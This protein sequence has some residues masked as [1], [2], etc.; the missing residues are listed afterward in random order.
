MPLAARVG[1]RSSHAGKV[2]GPGV[3]TVIVAGRPAAVLGDKH[4]C[5]RRG[6]RPHGIKPIVSG[7]ATVLIGGRPA[8]KVGDKIGCLAVITTGAASVIIGG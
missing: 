6:R 7:S 1:D 2:V 8:A 4:A 5:P 3:S